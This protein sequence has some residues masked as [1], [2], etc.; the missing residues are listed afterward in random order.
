MRTTWMIAIALLI[1]LSSR[2][3]AEVYRW[4]DPDGRTR[5]TLVEKSKPSQATR[6]RLPPI[7]FPGQTRR[8]EPGDE[9]LPAN[10]AVG[11]QP[12]VA[13]PPPGIEALEPEDD[14]S[15]DSELSPDLDAIEDEEQS[16]LQAKILQDREFLKE[17]IGNPHTEGHH[18]IDK[19]EVRSI[20][21]RLPRLQSELRAL[22]REE[23]DS[24]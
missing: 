17:L 1:G 7:L 12:D 20:A 21:D 4:T 18:L 13:A 6:R 5:Y 14:W 22:K 9:T 24:E 3:D 19:P 2:A 16:E 11:I 23:P 15:F 10:A 8:A